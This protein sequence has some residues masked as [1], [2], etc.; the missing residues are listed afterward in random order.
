M[1]TVLEHIR[2]KASAWEQI[3]SPS[4]LSSAVGSLANCIA[5]RLINDIFDMS[6]M[7]VTEAETAAIIIS[8]VEKLDDLFLPVTKNGQSNGHTA[9]EEQVPM[10]AQF[11]DQWMKMKYLSQT[12]QSNLSDI[13]FL[14]F[15]S[16][17]SLYF[18]VDE[19]VDL[20]ELSFENNTSVRSE[21]RKIRE[22][23]HPMPSG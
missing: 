17:L 4:A 9:L 5:A 8:Q 12:L 13:H 7:S 2:A 22:N 1:T 6:S 16:E 3:L 18:T 21:I 10:T 11:A 15:E 19:V 23:P 14:W 20:I